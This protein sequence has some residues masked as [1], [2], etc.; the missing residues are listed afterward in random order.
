LED[1]DVLASS[2]AVGVSDVRGCLILSRDGLILVWHPA[3]ADANDAA[4]W[5][6]S[7]AL[8]DPERGFAR[9]HL[10]AARTLR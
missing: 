10:V 1:F 4:A 5:T 3:D 8:G 9:F 2:H 6:R 7:S